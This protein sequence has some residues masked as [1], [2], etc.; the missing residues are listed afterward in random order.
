MEGAKS[1]EKDTASPSNT[2]PLLCSSC[3]GSRALSPAPEDLSLSGA[4]NTVILGLGSDKLSQANSHAPLLPQ[5]VLYHSGRCFSNRS[6]DLVPFI[7]DQAEI[8]KEPFE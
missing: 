5:H 2:G 3:E 4:S 6:Q 1:T 7:F 8:P